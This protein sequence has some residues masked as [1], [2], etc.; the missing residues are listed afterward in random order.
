MKLLP[1]FFPCH[2]RVHPANRLNTAS[3][4]S[5]RVLLDTISLGHPPSPAQ[6]QTLLVA[7]F[8]LVKV[9]VGLHVYVEPSSGS[10]EGAQQAR[11]TPP[12]L[13]FDGLLLFFSFIP[14]CIRMRKNNAQIPRESIKTPRAWTPAVRDLRS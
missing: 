3:S 7:P 12:P 6:Q 13:K 2:R 11:A 4:V 9:R 5:S 10:I 8:L 14:F 1:S